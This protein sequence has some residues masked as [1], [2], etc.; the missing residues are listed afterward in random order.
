MSATQRRQFSGE[1]TC[2]L[3]NGNL[4]GSRQV[5]SPT[6][7]SRPVGSPTA[8]CWGADRSAPQRQIADLSAPQR[9]FAGE[10]TRPLPNARSD[11]SVL[12][13]RYAGEPT[14]LGSNADV[15]L[16]VADPDI[17]IRVRISFLTRSSLIVPLPHRSMHISVVCNYGYNSATTAG[18]S[19][20]MFISYT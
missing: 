1:P 4:L 19:Q 13:R 3:P 20:H 12:Q 10:P 14:C 2:R 15:R 11:L 7:D 6:P 17:T 9:Q 16:V 5:C 8:I 18:V